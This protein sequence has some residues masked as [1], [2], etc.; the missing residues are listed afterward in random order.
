MFVD[1]LHA[2]TIKALFLVPVGSLPAGIPKLERIWLWE[3][4]G[5]EHRRTTRLLLPYPRTPVAVAA[6][7]VA[8]A[9]AAVA[10][11]AVAAPVQLKWSRVVRCAASADILLAASAATRAAAAA[12]L[13]HNRLRQQRRPSSLL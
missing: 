6:A 10:A 12:L 11:A 5:I 2:Q 4:L 7:A 3:G 9:A 13:Q 1:W 8:A